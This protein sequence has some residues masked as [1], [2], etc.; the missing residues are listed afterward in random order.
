MSAGVFETYGRYYDLLY[1]DKDYQGE[2]EYI[3]SV[4]HR[5]DPQIHSILEF[6]SGT[7]RHG[8]LLAGHG[9]NVVGIERSET[10]AKAA[11]RGT[12]APEINTGTFDCVQGDIRNA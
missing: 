1:R 8:K 9:F 7:G 3:A 6:G 2:A 5:A 4:L 10:M 11:T 12:G